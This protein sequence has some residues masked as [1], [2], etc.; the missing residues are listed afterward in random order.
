MLVEMPLTNANLRGEENSSEREPSESY[1]M[2]KFA[3]I[4]ARL[5]IYS[6]TT[7]KDFPFYLK[8]SGTDGLGSQQL[9]NNASKRTWMW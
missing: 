3:S 8:T 4:F 2:I 7:L 5:E 9:K 1:R 6:S